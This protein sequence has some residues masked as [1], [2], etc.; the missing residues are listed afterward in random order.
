MGVES[1][2][3]AAPTNALILEYAGAA[4]LN[5]ACA[6]LDSVFRTGQPRSFLVKELVSRFVL[7]CATEVPH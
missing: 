5:Q 3:D 1:R 6:E 2:Q 4:F 7:A